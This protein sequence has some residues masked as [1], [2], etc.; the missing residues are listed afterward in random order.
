MQWTETEIKETLAEIGRRSTSDSDYR[1]LALRDAKAAIKRITPKPIPESFKIKFIEDSGAGMTVVLPPAK[2]K[3]GVLSDDELE[4]VSGGGSGNKLASADGL[5]E[6][7]AT[8][9]GSTQF[10]TSANTLYVKL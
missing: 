10:L 9:G 6:L 1:S 3:D 5:R 8:S 2:S 7:S 4:L